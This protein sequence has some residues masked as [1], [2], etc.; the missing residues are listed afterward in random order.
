MQAVRDG[1]SRTAEVMIRTISRRGQRALRRF[2]FLIW[3][4]LRALRELFFLSDLRV[5]V[6]ILIH[7]TLP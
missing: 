7:D 3:R 4:P 5:S 2:L 1:D 6:V